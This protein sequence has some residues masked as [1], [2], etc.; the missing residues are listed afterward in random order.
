[1]ERGHI[2]TKAVTMVSFN[3]HKSAYG[4]IIF[5]T[6]LSFEL[7]CDLCSFAVSRLLSFRLCPKDLEDLEGFISKTHVVL[8]SNLHTFP[9]LNSFAGC[10]LNS[11]LSQQSYC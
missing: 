9:S 5:F 8:S 4:C 3:D 11:A 10:T 1:M 7:I 2:Q 6:E